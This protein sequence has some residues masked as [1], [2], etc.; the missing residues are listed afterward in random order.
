MSVNS[1]VFW[2]EKSPSSERGRRFEET[3]P[4]S[5]GS[6]SRP[7]KKSAEDIRLSLPGPSVAFLLCLLFKPED[8]D[9]MF[10]RNASLSHTPAGLFL[11]LLIELEDGK[12]K[13]LRIASLPPV[14]VAF[15]LP[16]SSTVRME[17]IYSSESSG[18]LRTTSLYNPE[19]G[20]LQLRF[21]LV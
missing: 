8:G 2:V 10:L 5:L 14:S 1:T 6:K 7:R 19:D 3:S 9:N 12:D 4:P 17:A 16:S 15:L 20:T 18:S 13:F 11:G 21:G